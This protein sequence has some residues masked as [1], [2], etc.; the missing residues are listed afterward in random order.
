[1][2]PLAVIS[3]QDLRP[4]DGIGLLVLFVVIVVLVMR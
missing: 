1:M 3:W 4:S 2:S